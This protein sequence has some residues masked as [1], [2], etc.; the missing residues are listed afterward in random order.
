MGKRKTPHT[1][2][3]DKPPTTLAH[4]GDVSLIT[5]DFRAWLKGQSKKP[6]KL[7][8]NKSGEDMLETEA[9]VL[10][11][12]G[13]DFLNKADLNSKEQAADWVDPE[14]GKKVNPN[15]V[16][17]VCKLSSAALYRSQGKLTPRQA[18]AAEAV[19]FAW[20]RNLRTPPAIKKVQVDVS[21]KPDAHIAILIDR[22]SAYAF[23][24][25]HVPRKGVDVV[26]H[27]A[28]DD[29]RITTLPGYRRVKHM[30]L[31]RESLDAVADGIGI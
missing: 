4:L 15:G 2:K 3:W 26:R 12:L 1:P 10:R 24:M 9:Q 30:E 8:E 31:L 29:K 7:G 22:V 6:R 11:R 20:E 25:S 19:L 23:V 13:R 16:K 14:T 5:A 18:N 28:R 27:V 21:S 17:R